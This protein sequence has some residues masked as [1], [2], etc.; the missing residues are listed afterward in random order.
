M[1][2]ENKVVQDN[3]VHAEVDEYRELIP[4]MNVN[5]PAQKIEDDNLVSNEAMLGIYAEILGKIRDDR[6]E[7]DDFLSKF[8]NMVFNDGDATTSSKEALVNLVKLKAESSDKMSKIADLM[9]RVKLR[10]PF[11][12]YL[13]QDNTINIGNN[14][15]RRALLQ[16]INKAQK[17]EK[18]D[19][20]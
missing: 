14:G 1:A 12:K 7:I 5:V 16:A 19:E 18:Q 9:T 8:S 10:D 11:P 17:R 2:S 20:L 4:T 3:T 6:T 15:S 13:R